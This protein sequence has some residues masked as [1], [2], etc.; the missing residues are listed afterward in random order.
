MER[1]L[2]H[3]AKLK[4]ETQYDM[5]QCTTVAIKTYLKTKKKI[6]LKRVLTCISDGN[7]CQNK[8]PNHNDGLHFISLIAEIFNEYKKWHKLG[9][10]AVVRYSDQILRGKRTACISNLFPKNYCLHF[11]T[12][13]KIMHMTVWVCLSH[14]VDVYND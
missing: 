6:I 3:L 11:L 9:I 14:S 10:Q 2:R 5:Y 7:Q 8:Q 1:L 4:K 13:G 12:M